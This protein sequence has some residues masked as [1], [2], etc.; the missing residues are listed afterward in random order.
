MKL[1]LRLS[2][3]LGVKKQGDAL[4]AACGLSHPWTSAPEWALRS[5]GSWG[6]DAVLGGSVWGLGDP[7]G[8]DSLLRYTPPKTKCK[9]NSPEAKK[10][11]AD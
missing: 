1:R 9:K 8:Q 7:M 2:M 5:A 4:G 11:K 10:L 6:K 3:A